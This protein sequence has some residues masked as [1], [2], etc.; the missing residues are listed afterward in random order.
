MRKI[1]LVILLIA[2]SLMHMQAQTAAVIAN[3]KDGWHKIAET[4][5]NFD[6]EKDE[7]LILGADR[8]ASIRFKVTDAPVQLIRIEV[9]YESGDHQNI[10]VNASISQDAES[11]VIDLNGGERSLKKVV[12]YYKTLPNSADK[13]AH[14]E[15]WGM[16]TNQSE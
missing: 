8:F 6:R 10:D 5:V 11:K 7:I 16:K 4:I 1:L 15:L 12:F 3:D 9:Y 2:A 13:K 14:M